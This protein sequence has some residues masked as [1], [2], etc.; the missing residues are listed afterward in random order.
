MARG[1]DEAAPL[2]CELRRPLDCLRLPRPSVNTPLLSPEGLNPAA[3]KLGGSIWA[4][5]QP[6][7]KG[8]TEA[9]P[10][11]SL[12]S[13]GHR[14]PYLSKHA[15]TPVHVKQTRTVAY[16]PPTMGD[17]PSAETPEEAHGSEAPQLAVATARPALGTVEAPGRVG[18]EPQLSMSLNEYQARRLVVRRRID[19]FRHLDSDGTARVH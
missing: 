8:P 16:S 18:P 3:P 9:G 15:R 12:C 10:Q 5:S 19:L 6:E 13:E 14:L 1:V 11:G 2:Y 4:R 7:M 17:V